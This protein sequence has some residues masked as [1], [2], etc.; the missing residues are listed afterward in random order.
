[1]EINNIILEQVSSF[2]FFGCDESPTVD[3]DVQY[4]YNICK[5]MRGN[6]NK[7]VQPED[8]KLNK[9][10]Q[11]III[12]SSAVPVALYR[13]ETWILS[14]R[15]EEKLRHIM[16]NFW[17]VKNCNLQRITNS[18]LR[19]KMNIFSLENKVIEWKINW[20]YHSERMQKDHLP[21]SDLYYKPE[22]NV[23]SG[24]RGLA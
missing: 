22:V 18:T 5:H 9:I 7:F 17:A 13:S 8:R 20:G 10:F 24:T 1:M 6:L 16:W 4:K 15:I 3:C 14:K 23:V 2:N 19:Q 21:Q 11:D 12:F